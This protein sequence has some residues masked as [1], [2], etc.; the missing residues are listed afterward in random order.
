MGYIGDSSFTRV[1]IEFEGS[2]DLGNC[3][4]GSDFSGFALVTHTRCSERCLEVIIIVSGD[5]LLAGCLLN[6]GER[7]SS[8][9]S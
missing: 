4:A 9:G 2:T 7:H 6:E 8:A 1:F 3:F 5:C